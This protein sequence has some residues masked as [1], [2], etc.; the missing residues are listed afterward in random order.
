MATLKLTADADQLLAQLSGGAKLAGGGDQHLPVGLGYSGSKFRA[1]IRFPN[2]ATGLATGKATKITRVLLEVQANS[3]QVHAAFGS[4][5]HCVIERLTAAI[6]TNTAKASTEGGSGWGSA[7]ATVFG[8]EKATATHAV[9]GVGP[10]KGNAKSYDVTQLVCD[11]LPATLQRPDGTACGGAAWYGIRIRS[12]SETS[13]AEAF[14]LLAREAAGYAGATLTIDYVS[15]RPPTGVPTVT[16]RSGAVPQLTISA[17][18]IDPD[19]DKIGKY[20]VE[21]TPAGGAAVT[22]LNVA[23][24]I[25]ADGMTATHTWGGA[26][27]ARGVIS[28]RVRTYHAGVA[29]GWSAPVAGWV[30]HDPTITP[31]APADG[32]QLPIGDLRP[33]LSVTVADPDGGAEQHRVQWRIA[34]ADASGHA[35]LGSWPAWAQDSPGTVGVFGW[36]VPANL[37]PGHYVWQAQVWG[38]R[39]DGSSYWG[40]STPVW[41]LEVR[42]T[43][44][45]VTVDVAA[46][47]FLDVP[48]LSSDYCAHTGSAGIALRVHVPVSARTTA[49]DAI[50]YVELRAAIVGGAALGTQ[51]L[52]AGIATTGHATAEV[53][54]PA[55]HSAN[56]HELE[57][58][59][60]AHSRLGLTSS[61]TVRARIGYAIG[62]IRPNVGLGSSVASLSAT[63]TE[64]AGDQADAVSV[65]YRACTGPGITAYVAGSSWHRDPADAER[66]LPA[67]NAYLAVHVQTVRLR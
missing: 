3:S 20:D 55:D 42:G 47:A 61:A 66:E 38:T 21:I 40:A 60:T 4:G 46:G 26:T 8:E 16:V 67:Q 51:R 59:A 36:Q 18:G 30:D 64:P 9:S 54:L 53:A 63:V 27:L 14:E 49:P 41:S 1:L 11:A 37:S 65:W 31:T 15:D 28:V 39:P 58:T 6:D 50:D 43:A 44:P 12:T 22:E 35:P 62:R 56:G 32:S 2:P 5:R 57:L 10:A 33:R 19:G 34:P 23:T 52:P 24:G 29:T 7:S 13:T 45:T 17:T 25:A 48:A